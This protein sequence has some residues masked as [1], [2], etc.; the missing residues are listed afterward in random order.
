MDHTFDTVDE[1][2]AETEFFVRKMADADTDGLAF[3]CYLSAYLS[4]ARTCTLALQRFCGVVPG[5][6]EW[7]EPHRQR[8]KSSQTARFILD[9]RNEHVHGGA[10]PISSARIS[11]RSATYEF[12]S[13]SK[14]HQPANDV[15]TTCRDHL[16]VLLE[17]VY[18]CYVQLGVHID[19]QQYYS[20]ENYPGGSIDAA[21][22][23]IYGWV[24]ESLIDEG[25]DEDARW[26]ELRS[27]AY[28]PE[29]KGWIH[30]PA[31]FSSPEGFQ[32]Y[33]AARRPNV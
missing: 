4:A 12:A 31:G 16:V 27:L 29:E 33:M 25:F 9:T 17:I 22:T 24:C 14:G 13:S 26:N 11:R 3:N 32:S 30:A 15:L 23:E 28:T 6:A 2:L 5:F 19:P 18:D 10:Y 7:Y 20:R 8:L 21:E 1:K